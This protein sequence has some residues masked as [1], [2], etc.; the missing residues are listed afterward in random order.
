MKIEHDVELDA[1]DAATFLQQAYFEEPFADVLEPR[2]PAIDQAERDGYK[3]LLRLSR[4]PVSEAWRCIDL[5]SKIDVV[6][7]LIRPEALDSP[8][9]AEALLMHE[10]QM[11]GRLMGTG[12]T[13]PLR[14]V[15]AGWSS[16]LAMPYID[17]DSLTTHCNTRSLELR[18][19]LRLF[20]RCVDRVARIHERGVVHGDLKPEHLLINTDDE[21]RPVVIDFGL[22]SLREHTSRSVSGM[23]HIGGTGDYMAPRALRDG[24][25][26]PSHTRC[27]FARCCARPAD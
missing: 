1:R 20:A 10:A 2:P 17:G 14:Q 9:D 15:S 4:S 16:F 24:L 27:L 19:R 25:S 3:P 21:E 7:K 26:A 5:T 11:L 18:A 13:L 22:A 23:F 6:I 12:V 8:A